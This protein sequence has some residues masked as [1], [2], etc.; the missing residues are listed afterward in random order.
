MLI[1]RSVFQFVFQFKLNP[2]QSEE[3]IHIRKERRRKGLEREYAWLENDPD[4]LIYSCDAN[5]EDLQDFSLP[6]VLVG[7]D[8]ASLYP[9]CDQV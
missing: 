2:F 6:M 3:H 1:G 4:R 9:S 7:S 5:P 8:V